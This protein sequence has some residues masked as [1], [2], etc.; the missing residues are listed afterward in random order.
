MVSTSRHTV[1]TR[2]DAAEIVLFGAYRD[3]HDEAQRIVRRF[4]ASAAP[5]RIA[6]DHG[7]RIVLR[8]EE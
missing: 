4:A 3:V 1:Q 8:R 2:Y 5:Y 7:E 6:E